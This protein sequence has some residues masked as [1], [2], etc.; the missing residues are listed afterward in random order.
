MYSIYQ[1]LWGSLCNM[2]YLVHLVQKTALQ[3]RAFQLPKAKTSCS[4]KPLAFLHWLKK[5]T[6]VTCQSGFR[7][8]VLILL[9]LYRIKKMISVWV[10]GAFI[11]L[12]NQSLPHHVRRVDNLTACMINEAHTAA[13]QGPAILF[14]EGW[15][16]SVRR[17]RPCQYVFASVP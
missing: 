11:H 3:K 17:P 16:P 10:W 5:Q 7:G 12:S 1:R 9:C 8:T 13:I 14:H 6:Q 2:L 15:L 4:T